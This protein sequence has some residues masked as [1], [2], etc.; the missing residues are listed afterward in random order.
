MKTYIDFSMHLK[1]NNTKRKSSRSTIDPKYQ[2][3]TLDRRFLV[4]SVRRVG[5]K[6][7]DYTMII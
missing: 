3:R 6:K 5:N 7:I 4:R 1:L 2:L